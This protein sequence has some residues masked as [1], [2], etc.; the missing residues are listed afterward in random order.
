MNEGVFVLL[1]VVEGVCVREG[2]F[3]LVLELVL[4]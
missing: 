1:D 3:E 2:V 4:V